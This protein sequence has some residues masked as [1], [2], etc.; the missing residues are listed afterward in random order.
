M[1]ENYS[2]GSDQEAGRRATQAGDEPRELLSRLLPDFDVALVV[3][4]LRDEAAR[5]AS[6]DAS[7]MVRRGADL[8]PAE[9]ELH[10]V[11]ADL[12]LGRSARMLQHSISNP[13]TALLAEAQLL[14]LEPLGEEQRT[15][16]ERIVELARRVALVVRRLE[17]G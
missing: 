15:A 9:L 4:A 10:R 3:R 1:H 2:G 13:L 6:D 7:P 17:T 11:R 16:V 8:S 5:P 12:A 14:E